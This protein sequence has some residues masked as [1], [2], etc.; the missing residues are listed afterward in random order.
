MAESFLFGFL[1]VG[2]ISVLSLFGDD[3]SEIGM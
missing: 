3:I 2:A 1:I